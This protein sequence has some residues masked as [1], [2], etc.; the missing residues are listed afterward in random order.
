M[1]TAE[2]I[3]GIEVFAM[4]SRDEQ[5]R[6]ARAA[7]DVTLV[8]GEYAANEGDDRALFAVLDG[9]IEA[10]KSRDGVER[11]VGERLPGDI[12]GEVPIVLGAPFPVGFRASVRSRVM[13]ISP[14]EY[15]AIAA[16]DSVVPKAI[17]ALAQFRMTGERGLQGLASQAPPPRAIVVGHRWD[18]ACA[19][20]RQFLHR[21]QISFSWVRPDAPEASAAWEGALPADA[22]LPVIR[23]A[24]GKTVVRPQLRRVAELLGLGTE[25]EA[26][27]YDTIVIGAGPAGLAA[28]VYGAS[29][30]LRTVVVEREAPGGQAGTSSR[31]ENYL[32]FPSGVSGEELSRRAGSEPRS[33]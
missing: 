23:F 18:P 19:L 12:F 20:L 26:A 1:V 33:W 30:G 5:E 31:I 16:V 8:A 6:L 21:N 29:E 13:R 15:H 14:A 22:D 11:V 3:A 24:G 28:A 10:V 25:P 2:E 27:E 9:R 4:L 32:G 17:G 7:A